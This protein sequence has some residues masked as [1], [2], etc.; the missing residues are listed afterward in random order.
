M[1]S[2]PQSGS[3]PQT[4]QRLP[5]LATDGHPRIGGSCV[6]PRTLAAIECSAKCTLARRESQ[7]EG[8][9]IAC[10]SPVALMNCTTL[11]ATMR[12]RAVFVLKLSRGPMKHAQSLRLQCGGLQGLRTALE[13]TNND[14]HDLVGKA[15]SRFGGIQ[16]V[17]WHAVARALPRGIRAPDAPSRASEVWPVRPCG[18][19]CLRNP[20]FRTT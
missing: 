1:V 8:E 18:P 4:L 19:Q 16:D 20:A 13:E 14:V 17:P 10:S 7:A 12:E 15:Q 5:L 11:V 3:P 9:W 6:E 2:R